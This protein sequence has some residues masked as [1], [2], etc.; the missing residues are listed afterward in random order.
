MVQVAAHALKDGDKDPSGGAAASLRPM[1][2]HMQGLSL[3]SRSP[4]HSATSSVPSHSISEVLVTNVRN[5]GALYHS[6]GIRR[7]PV[8]LA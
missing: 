2:P 6:I 4:T 1:I 7:R 3:D 5:L 8:Q